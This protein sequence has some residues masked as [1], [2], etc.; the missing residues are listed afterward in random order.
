MNKGPLTE[1]MLDN[2]EGIA[3]SSWSSVIIYWMIDIIT[4]VA[5]G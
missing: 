3:A 2:W 1:Y 5:M 4:T